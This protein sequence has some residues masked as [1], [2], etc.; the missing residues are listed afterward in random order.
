[1]DGA[2]VVWFEEDFPAAADVLCGSIS[3]DDCAG[4][5]SPA[6]SRSAEGAEDRVSSLARLRRWTFQK[7]ISAKITIRTAASLPQEMPL[8]T[9]DSDS[10]KVPEAKSGVD[11]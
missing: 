7:A 8:E 4:D 9:P 1:M 6:G 3:A 5:C 2:D 10:P 11:C